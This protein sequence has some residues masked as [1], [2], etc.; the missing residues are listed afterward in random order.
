MLLRN[1]NTEAGLCNGSRGVVVDI[2]HHTA[3]KEQW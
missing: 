2:L 1:L 3:L